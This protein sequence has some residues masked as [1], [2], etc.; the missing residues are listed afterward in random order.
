[1]TRRAVLFGCNY[2]GSKNAL[3][4]C[5]NDVRAVH[6]MLQYAYGFD[7]RVRCSFIGLC[8]FYR[9]VLVRCCTMSAMPSWLQPAQGLASSPQAAAH[10][11]V[12]N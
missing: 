12:L 3:S 8:S 9:A 6:E 11:A 2:A 5:I 10:G 7:E 4:G 1:M